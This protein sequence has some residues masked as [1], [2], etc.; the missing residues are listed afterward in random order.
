[1]LPPQAD[2]PFCAYLNSQDNQKSLVK[3]LISAAF[4]FAIA[5]K[6]Q[7]HLEQLLQDTSDLLHFT[8]RM[9]AVSCAQV[10]LPTVL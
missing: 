7:L 3:L 2:L 9:C 1:M 8:I 6:R 10:Y 4:E 5:E